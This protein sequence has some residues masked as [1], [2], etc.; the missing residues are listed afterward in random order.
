VACG[1]AVTLNQLFAE[2]R[3]LTD[4]DVEPVYAAPR[5]G[6]VRHSLADLARS[7]RDLGYEP[8]VALREGLHRSIE[9]LRERQRSGEQLAPAP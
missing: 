1:A 7:R 8:S 3:E 4:S 2:L 6:D 9:H 5:A